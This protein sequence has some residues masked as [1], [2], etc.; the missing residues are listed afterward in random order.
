MKKFGINGALI[1]LSGGDTDATY[2]ACAAHDVFV[3]LSLDG[4]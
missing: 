4:E 2:F 3:L 1:Y